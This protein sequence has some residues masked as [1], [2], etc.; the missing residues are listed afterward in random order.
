MGGRFGPSKMTNNHG[1]DFELSDLEKLANGEE[2][3]NKCPSLFLNPKF[4]PENSRSPELTHH[5]FGK[6]EN[7]PEGK[8]Y[9]FGAGTKPQH[10]T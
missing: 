8:D 4:S 1:S 6:A 3:G 7:L 10:P 2:E 5:D 9:F